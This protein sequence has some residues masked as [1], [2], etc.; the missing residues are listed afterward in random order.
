[1]VGATASSELVHRSRE[2]VRFEI[3]TSAY[4]AAIRRLLRETPMAGQ[5]QISLEREPELLRR[6]RD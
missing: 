2:G 4:D 5:I 6:R 1:M 3:A